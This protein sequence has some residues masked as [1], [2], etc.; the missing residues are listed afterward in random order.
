ML[1]QALEQAS[2]L[3]ADLDEEGRLRSDKDKLE[4]DLRE[5]YL[6]LESARAA[7]ESLYAGLNRAHSGLGPI[8]YKE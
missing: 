4:H 8:C 7:A 1:P 6:G 5:T 2:R 3:I